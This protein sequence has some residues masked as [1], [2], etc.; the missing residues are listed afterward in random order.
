MVAD[1]QAEVGPVED[2][3]LEEEVPASQA[4]LHQDDAA[5]QRLVQIDCH[6][7]LRR[8]LLSAGLS[9]SA[10]PSL[11]VMM[12]MVMMMI[13]MMMVMMVMMMMIMV[14]MMMMMTKPTAVTKPT[15]RDYSDSGNTTH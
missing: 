12:M 14:M 13:M 8:L 10:A 3:H 5:G 15:N 11:V 2:E 4:E 7:A 1:A 9:W 6:V